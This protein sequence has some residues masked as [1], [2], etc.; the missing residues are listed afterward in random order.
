MY[1][2]LCTFLIVSNTLNL[3]FSILV[4]VVGHK[5]KN[6]SDEK[7]KPLNI[8]KEEKASSPLSSPATL[9]PK[10]TLFHKK[11]ESKALDTEPGKTKDQT[12]K[13]ETKTEEHKNKSKASAGN[14]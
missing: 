6:K 12:K 8:V 1:V 10:Q 3:C 11:G 9:S 7:I 4:L 2:I 14:F 13:G 5:E